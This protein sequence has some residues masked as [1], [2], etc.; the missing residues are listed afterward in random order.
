MD[1]G[2]TLANSCSQRES[3]HPVLPPSSFIVSHSDPDPMVN[4]TGPRRVS[5]TFFIPD[6]LRRTTRER[7]PGDLFEHSAWSRPGASLATVRLREYPQRRG[8]TGERRN[9]VIVGGL[10][11]GRNEDTAED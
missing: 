9:S 2:K 8:E 7:E 3:A 1:W 10:V 6:S 11:F 5:T 4:G